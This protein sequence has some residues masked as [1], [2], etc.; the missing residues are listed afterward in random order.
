MRVLHLIQRYRP[1]QGG[2]E[3]FFVEASERLAAEGHSVTVYT[4][5][6]LDIQRFWLWG[7]KRVHVPREVL[8]GVD[9]RRFRVWT[10][11]WRLHAKAQKVLS[12]IPGRAAKSLFSFPSP[13]VPGMLA[14]IHT[15]ERFDIVH[16]AAL[17]YDSILYCAHRIARRQKIPLIIS[18]FFHLGE[19][20]NDDVSKYY[21]RPHQMWLVGEAD[22]VLVQTDIEQEFLIERSI[23]REKL[24]LLGM[25]ISA[26]E[27][28]GGVGERFRDKYDV[29]GPIVF[30]IGPKTYDKG[31]FHLLEAMRRIWHRGDPTTL[32]LAGSD[33]EDFNRHYRGL[34]SEIQ[35]KCLLL[36]YISEEEKKDL[37]DAGTLMVMP[38]RSDSFGIVFLEAWYYG[39]PVIGAQAG[40]I[41]G[42]IND[43]IDGLL[44]P[45]DDVG[46]LTGAIS[47]M[48]RDGELSAEMGKRGHD[49]VMSSYTWDE[50][51]RLLKDLYLNLTG[52]EK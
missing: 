41:P 42:V 45:F 31:T 38:S 23:P 20:G 34:P 52:E 29:R 4:T 10:L 40:G 46:A 9:V 7:K 11:P 17:P 15:R 37:L 44:V 51:Y 6:A 27:L 24:R 18:P 30:Y 12:A 26:D 50:K 22:R 13:F 28:E 8:R 2:S 33:I 36:S 48:L 32:V 14:S 21:T 35:A 25:G 5:D 49:K 39:K 43:G 1:A 19:K 3:K 16:A 47:K